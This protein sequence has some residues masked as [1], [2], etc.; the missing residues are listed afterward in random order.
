VSGS[1]DFSLRVWDL[2]QDRREIA[3]NSHLGAVKDLLITDNDELIVS[4]SEDK[5]LKVWP[6]PDFLD[7]QSFKVIGAEFNSVAQFGSDIVSC[8]SD[9]KLRYWNREEDEAGLVHTT[10][11]V[12]LKLAVSLDGSVLAVGDD[13]G[14]LYLFRKDYEC[15]KEFQAHKGPIRDMVFLTSGELATGGGDSKILLWSIDSWQCRQMKG[16]QQSIWCFGYCPEARAQILVSGSSDKTIRV[17]NL[18]RAEEVSAFQVQEQATAICVTRDS[19]YVISGGISGTIIV[20]SLAEKVEESVFSIHTDMVTGIYVTDNC[21]IAFT[22]SKDQS[23]QFVSLLYRIPLTFITRKQPILCMFVSPNAEEII[24]GESQMIYIQDNPFT[25]TRTR[26]LGPEDNVQKFL[27]Y[28]KGLTIGQQVPHDISMDKFI[29]VP[30]FFNTLHFYSAMGLR[31][32]LAASLVESAMIFP[33]R[34]GY[35]PLSIALHKG[36]NG[37]RDDVVDALIQ[38]GSTNP[39]L[40]QILENVLVSMNRKAFPRL[41][42]IYEAI[43]QT[44]LRKSLPKFCEPDIPLPLVYVS[45]HPRVQSEDFFLPEELTRIGKGILFKECYVKICY[46]MGSRESLEFVESLA[47]CKNLDVL[48]SPLV[49]DIV[50][51]KWENARYPIMIQGVCYYTYLLILSIYTANMYGLSSLG[52]LLTGIGLFLCN[53]LLMMY[54]LFQMSVSGSF[55]FSYLW[56]YIDWARGLLLYSYIIIKWTGEWQ[57]ASK[58]IFSLIIFLSFLRGFSYF[59]LFKLTRYLINLLAE[60]VKDIGGFFILLVYSTLAFCFLFIVLTDCESV[61]ASECDA[62]TAFATELIG[63]YNLVLGGLDTEA[64]L[65]FVQFICLTLALLINPIIMLNLLISIIGDTYDR[66][67]SDCLS[68]DSKELMD[69]IQEVE[70]ML[71]FRRNNN[72]KKFFQQCAEFEKTEEEAGWEGKFRALEVSIEKMGEANTEALNKIMKKMKVQDKYF[73]SQAEKIEKLT[74]VIEEAYSKETAA[75]PKG[76][77]KG[78]EKEKET[79]ARRGSVKDN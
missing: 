70:N 29:V 3:L 39:F 45:D 27:T 35:H 76:K 7:E 75:K 31:E 43:Y 62:R 40:F 12:G 28:M 57:G 58:S 10:N 26:V 79:G 18:E 72:V 15:V 46:I 59:R 11:G 69:M 61:S 8:G 66:V 24:T 33:S 52:I 47:A 63:S 4:C 32:H 54:E 2:D 53:T 60:V 9:R 44:A 55:Y 25:S 74:Q 51:Y 71:F 77:E 5:S 48:R 36:L 20:W 56:N 14:H 21:E 34:D 65:D 68:A 6:F 37:I 41:G 17:W 22:V 16:H 64:E 19:R 30:Y 23:I 49:Q 13:Y 1:S 73:A 38:L 42:K 50:T 78:K 67:Q